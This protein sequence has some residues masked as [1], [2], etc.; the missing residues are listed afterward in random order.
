MKRTMMY[1]IMR[2][3]PVRVIEYN[4][5]VYDV[6]P[7]H[8]DSRS[9]LQSVKTYVVCLFYYELIILCNHGRLLFYCGWHVSMKW[10]V[11]CRDDATSVLFDVV[12]SVA[13]RLQ[14]FLPQKRQK[15]AL[16]HNNLRK[17]ASLTNC[18]KIPL[19]L[20]HL[21]LSWSCQMSNSIT[22]LACGATS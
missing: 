12:A 8:A 14:S 17:G 18:M 10:S 7:R 22:N 21:Q 16:W 11:D 3:T 2:R 6:T 9:V 4:T 5:C 19:I 15:S 13:R 1:V 20:V